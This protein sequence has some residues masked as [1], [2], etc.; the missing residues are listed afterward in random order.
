MRK[1]GWAI[2]ILLAICSHLRGHQTIENALDV[3]ISQDKIVIDARIRVSQIALV[4]ADG[5]LAEKHQAYVLEHLKIQVDGQKLAGK[6]TTRPSIKLSMAEYRFEYALTNEPKVVSIYQDMLK[7]KQEVLC[8]AVVR[9]RQSNQ[10][11]FQTA[12]LTWSRSIEFECDW[13]TG[14]GAQGGTLRPDEVIVETKVDFGAMLWAYCAHGIQHILSGI[15]HLLFVSALVL[16][17]R[18][19]WDLFKVVT[20]FT[21]AHTLTLTLSVLNVVSLSERIVEPMIAASIVFVAVQNIFW[22]KQARGWSRL[23]IAFTFGLFHGLGFAGGLREAMSTM[24]AVALGIAL[25]GFSLGV[26]IGHQFV[27]IPLFAALQ[28]ARKWKAK[29]ERTLLMNRISTTGSALISLGGIYFFIHTM[30]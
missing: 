11:A 24:P 7:E 27:V 29:E 4:E 22:P 25:V 20:M 8:A 3:V 12:L 2:S 9:I 19:F 18:G 17:A 21:I 14:E 28:A 10:A 5:N 30:M 13:K 1:A 15:D 26:E 23:A 16:A 6:P